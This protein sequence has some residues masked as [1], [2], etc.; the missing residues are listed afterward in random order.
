MG[1]TKHPLRIAIYS[2][3]LDIF[4]GGERYILTIAEMLSSKHEVYFYADKQI[5]HNANKKFNICLNRVHFLT[6]DLFRANNL[7]TKLIELRNYDIFFYM[8]DGSLFFSSAKKNF[9]IVQSPAHL[10]ERNII[11]KL[12]FINWKILCYSTFMQNIIKKHLK[13]QAVILSPC[14]NSNQ[15]KTGFST[16]DNIILSVG[17]FFKKPHDKKQN[18]LIEIFKNNYNNGFS[19]WKLVIAGGLTEESG[20]EILINIKKNVRGFPIE[21]VVNPDFLQLLDLYK[22]AKLYWHAAGFGEDLLQFPERAEHFGITTLESMASGAVPIVFGAGG[23][24][25]IINDGINGYLWKNEKE[26]VDKSVNLIK[27]NNLLREMS[28]KATEGVQRFSCH[29]LNE[30]LE[31][32][33]Y[34]Q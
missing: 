32:I 27:N 5:R 29:K 17:R 31:K 30:Q 34:S 11:N 25:D 21:I 2:P 10:P 7:F 28:D 26:L 18:I 15:F 22:K 3:Y 16:K 6:N 20:E 12:K 1:K 13:K 33:T 14:I 24:L 9:I 23:Q 4:G 19:P 8:T